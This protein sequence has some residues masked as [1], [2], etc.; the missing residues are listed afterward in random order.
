MANLQTIPTE[1]YSPAA[2]LF[3]ERENEPHFFL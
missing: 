2:I 1:N 3:S